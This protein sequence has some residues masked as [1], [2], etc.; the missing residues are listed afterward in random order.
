[1]TKVETNRPNITHLMKSASLWIKRTEYGIGLI[2]NIT[3]NTK[4]MNYG[5]TNQNKEQNRMGFI[6]N[7]LFCN[8]IHVGYE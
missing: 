3:L 8:I 1:M 2:T 5:N 6:L 4:L 7:P